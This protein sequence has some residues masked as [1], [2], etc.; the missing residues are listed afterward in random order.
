MMGGEGWGKKGQA[1]LWSK[2]Q[3]KGRV[4]TTTVREGRR[5]HTLSLPI[6]PSPSLA[7]L[8]FFALRLVGWCPVCPMPGQ[9]RQ[10]PP[11]DK[12]CQCQCADLFI[13]IFILFFGQAPG[14][15]RNLPS[16]PRHPSPPSH[17][18]RSKKPRHRRGSDGRESESDKR[19]HLRRPKKNGDLE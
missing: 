9:C 7:S 12:C 19:P 11:S 5:A 17:S 1:G 13:F 14:L 18:A 15:V 3:E 8:F 4:R 2:R 6:A 10:L 16:L